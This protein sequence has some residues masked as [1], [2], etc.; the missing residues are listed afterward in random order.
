MIMERPLLSIVVPT[1]NRYYYLYFLIELISSFKSDEVEMV[2]QDNSDDN[3]EFLNTIDLEKNP[4]IRYFYDSKHLSQSEN[5][6]LSIKNSRGEYV[7]FIGDDDG[8]LPN[9][10]ETVRFLKENNIDALIASTVIYNWPDFVDKSIYHLSSSVQYK[11]GKGKYIEINTRNEIENCVKS[12]L[13]DLCRLPK[14]YQGIVR[15]KIL[16]KVYHRAGS[17]FPG[18]SPDMA[19]AIALAILTPKTLYYDSPL[20]ISGQSKSV[21]GGERLLNRNKLPNITKVPFLPKNISETWDERLPRYWCADT[22]WPQSAISAFHAMGVNLPKVNFN[23]ILATFIFDHPYYYKKCR[24]YVTNYISFV[25]FLLKSFFDKG[26]RFL[27][28]R[29]SFILSFRKKRA[30]VCIHRNLVSIVEAVSFL[31]SDIISSKK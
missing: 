20:I 29:L 16:D 22:I 28:W 6:D 30:G 19:N 25:Y 1:K 21:G 31:N 27:Y 11:K 17:F 7:C 9:I 12:G 15:R 3:S 5:S 14:V 8:I 26:F 18:G 4:F 23:Q 13:K 10:V 24:S 2:I